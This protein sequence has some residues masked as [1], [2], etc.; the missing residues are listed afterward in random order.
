ME[1][2]PPYPL[3]QYPA[4]ARLQGLEAA[5]VVAM[6]VDTSGAVES[7]TITLLGESHP[8]FHTPVCNAL[9]QWRYKPVM[10]D[11]RRRRAFVLA[12]ISFAVQ[13]GKL[14]DYRPTEEPQREAVRNLG[15]ANVFR[16]LDP[17]PHCG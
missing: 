3:P 12:P 13:G 1:I 9:R 2:L 17:K 16:L 5:I 10:R 7:R 4:K 15:W 11:G 8:I 14:W 6:I